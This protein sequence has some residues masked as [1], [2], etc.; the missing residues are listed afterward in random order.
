MVFDE[1]T[2]CKSVKGCYRIIVTA[3]GLYNLMKEWL[4]PPCNSQ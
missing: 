2:Q 3:L 1:P 4:M